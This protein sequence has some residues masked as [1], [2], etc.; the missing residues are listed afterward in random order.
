MAATY[1]AVICAFL[2]F[3]TFTVHGEAC[4]SPQILNE[5]VYST[6]ESFTA[7]ETAFIVEFA[8]SCKDGDKDLFL[9]ADIN[10]R[11]YPVSRIIDGNNEYQV[12]WTD[13]HKTTPT[14]QYV[15]KFY[16]EDG[17]SKLRKAQRSGESLSE[18]KPLFDV[19]FNHR[20]VSTGPYVQTE[21]LAAFVGFSVWYMAYNAKS[22]IQA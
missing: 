19:Q 15:I 14:G 5:R 22:K 13:E 12:S 17:Y 3:L 10:G 2:V 1:A 8:L 20:G 11:Q 16:D 6:E 9:H 4:T 7:S 21:V 18:I